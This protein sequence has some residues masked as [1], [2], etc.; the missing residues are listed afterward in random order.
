MT[1]R[2][3]TTTPSKAPERRRHRRASFKLSLFTL[4]VTLQALELPLQ[5]PR[6]LRALRLHASQALKLGRPLK[7]LHSQ[8]LHLPDHLLH[9]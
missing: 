1:R 8:L 6:F 4:I 7:Q 5:L 3:K 9:F 2:R